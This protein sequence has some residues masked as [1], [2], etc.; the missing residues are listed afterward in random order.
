MINILI[1]IFDSK[2]EEEN[3]SLG[4]IKN[5]LKCELTEFHIDEKHLSG[6][7]IDNEIH[8]QTKTLDI[9]FYLMGGESF[10]T[11]YKKETELLF[12]KIL[13]TR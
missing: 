3:E 2:K 10:R 7:W 6:Y 13:E 12:N 1:Y 4:F 9:V 5:D 8:D 11:P